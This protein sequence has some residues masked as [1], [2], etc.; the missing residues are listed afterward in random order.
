M[1]TFIN[2]GCFVFLI[3][4]GFCFLG[5]FVGVPEVRLFNRPMPPSLIKGVFQGKSVWLKLFDFHF[6]VVFSSVAKESFEMFLHLA[7]LKKNQTIEDKLNWCLSS[8]WFSELLEH[9]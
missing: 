5:F 7:Y 4:F 9:F 3:W 8:S 1:K 2:P 6:L